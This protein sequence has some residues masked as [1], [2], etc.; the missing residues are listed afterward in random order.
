MDATSI[1]DNTTVVA[2]SAVNRKELSHHQSD[3]VKPGSSRTQAHNKQTQAEFG[4]VSDFTLADRQFFV[5]IG[6]DGLIGALQKL[7]R[8]LQNVSL[9]PTK[10]LL[11]LY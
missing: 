4:G 3:F 5:A 6:H 7:D 1:A 10:L 2:S 11:F 9:F 8:E